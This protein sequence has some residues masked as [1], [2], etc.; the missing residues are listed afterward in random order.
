[1][2]L[3]PAARSRTAGCRRQVTDTTRREAGAEMT[4]GVTAM[5]SDGT[6]RP[7]R[8]AESMLVLAVILLLGLACFYG[9]RAALEPA[10]WAS[11][12]A[13]LASLSVAFVAMLVWAV[14][15]Y[16][17]EGHPRTL[18]GFLQRVRLE[19]V[20]P[21]VLL[22]GL[23]AGVVMFLSTALFSPL[24]ARATS[25]GW[26]PLPAGIPDYL[27]PAKQQSL[28]LLKE[29]FISQGI[30]PWIPIVL[31]L[32]IAAEEIFWRGM[33]F[34]RQ[35]VQHGKR[36]YF[37]HGLIWAFSHL[38]Q[39]WMLPPILIGSLALAWTVQHMR[40]TWVSVVAHLVNN[41][42]PFTLMLLFFT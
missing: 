23:G 37:V 10:G 16:L 38:L 35:E 18:R 3:V 33:V 15:A 24:L 41:G 8:S 26:L 27:N 25:A 19:P 14:A 2:P 12:P 34:P 29:Q 42:L 17:A 22:W 6:I 9:L 4:A 39:Y 1:M 40:T 31:I 28:A 5:H 21:R 13:Y 11:Y 7:M 36:T 20:G 32:H 30:L